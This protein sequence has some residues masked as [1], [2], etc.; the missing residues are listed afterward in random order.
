MINIYCDESCHL[1]HDNANTMLMGAISCSDTE[2]DRIYS[3]IR[4]IK[5][6]HGLSSWTEIKW[7]GVSQSKLDF[8]L[9]LIDYF[10]N[11]EALSFRAVVV[12]NKS[13]LDHKKY[14]QGSHDLWY[15]KT[16]YYLLDAIV[17]YND[18]YKIMID[19]KDT[20]GGPKVKKLREVLC[21]NKYDFKG[22]VIKGI[23]QIQ[24]HESDIMQ[25]TD[26]I[27]GAIG[28]YHNGHYGNPEASSAKK[29]VVDHL[30]KYYK[31]PIMWGTSRSATKMNIFLW[32]LVG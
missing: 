30:F 15:Y 28:F 16:Y 23:Y 3:Q 11:E 14:N 24:S 31:S 22:E 2:K 7:T 20:R 12:K 19:I 13:N 10:V 4:A 25:L 9:E 6:R 5:N 29:A 8:Y 21:N 17:S 1:E 32:K 27:V 18:E 26:L